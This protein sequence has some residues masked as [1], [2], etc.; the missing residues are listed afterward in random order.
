MI[1][2][3]CCSPYKW[4]DPV[5]QNHLQYLL[6]KNDGYVGFIELRVRNEWLVEQSYN[7]AKSGTQ[8]TPQ[9]DA[10]SQN[11]LLD[12]PSP[13]M[14]K[15]LHVGHLRAGV[16]GDTLARMLHFQGHVVTRHSHVGDVG[17]A[18]ATIV[19]QSLEETSRQHGDDDTVEWTPKLL[20]TWYEKGKKRNDDDAFQQQVKET[21]LRIQNM[22][23]EPLDGLVQETWKRICTISRV[24]FQDIWTKLDVHSTERAESSYREAVPSILEELKKLENVEMSRNVLCV[25]FQEGSSPLVIQKSDGGYLYATIDFAAA[26]ERLQSRYDRILYITDKS[27]ELHFKQLFETL[28]KVGW[29]DSSTC[30]LEHVPFGL[31]LGE[32]GRK[33]SSR[34]GKQ[35]YNIYLEIILI[36]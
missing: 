9:N 8:T 2:K 29:Y 21:V 20:S 30:S 34:N 4:L 28:Q 1:H 15:A 27:Q 35:F 11:I 36:E 33:L 24:G 14:G 23:E 17:A 32:N 7:M 6:V 13:N 10:F 22:S 31:V 25:F 16:I 19:V 5:G 3:I 12:F 26:K 18:M